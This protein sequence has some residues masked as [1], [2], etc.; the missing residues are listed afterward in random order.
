MSVL[1]KNVSVLQPDM[2]VLDNAYLGVDGDRIDY[3]GA[4]APEKKYAE[5]R[6]YKDKLLIPGLVNAHTHAAMTLLRGVGSDLRLQDWLFNKIF[7]IEDKLTAEDMRVGGSLAMLEMLRTGTTSFSDMYFFPHMLCEAVGEA[8]M[9]ANISRAVVAAS[10]DERWEDSFRIRE[11]VELFDSYHNSFDGRI[12]ID[13]CV[14]AEYTNND[15]IAHRLG[16]LCDEKGAIMHVHVSETRSEHDECVARHGCTP[17]Q[18]LDKMGCLNGKALLAHG[19]WLSDEDME[20]IYAKK[21]SVVHNPTSNMKLGSGF[22]PVQKMLDM[23][24]RVGLGTD[25]TASNNNLDMLEEMHLAAVIHNGYTGDP[26][27]MKPV[28]II[29]MATANGAYAQGRED[30]G[31]LAVGLKADIAAIDLDKPHLIP[32]LDTLALLCYSVQGSDVCMTMVDGKILYENGEYKTLDKE[33]IYFDVRKSV[34]RL[35]R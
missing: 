2:T 8:G 28:D 29:K 20:L 9:K 25:G 30:T 26:T 17:V 10:P 5:T 19:I 21:L 31:A 3:I 13:L 34:E 23:G 11:S 24:I 33:K 6:D 16:E 14:H 4:A 27:I 35:Y 7:P 1:F 32:N 18:W 15:S 12:K 22:A